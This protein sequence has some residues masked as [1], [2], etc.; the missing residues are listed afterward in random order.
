MAVQN[1]AKLRQAALILSYFKKV[2]GIVRSA[3]ICAM[4]A[5]PG[6]QTS[7]AGLSKPSVDGCMAGTHQQ[8][9]FF[10]FFDA[11][12]LHSLGEFAEVRE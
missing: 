9:H 10:T 4:T 1:H 5:A 2:L 6:G 12:L 11:P 7:R 8:G 3:F